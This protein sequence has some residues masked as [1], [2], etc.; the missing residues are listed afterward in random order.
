MLSYSNLAIVKF[1]RLVASLALLDPSG[2][3]NVTLRMIADPDWKQFRCVFVGLNPHLLNVHS[4]V[5]GTLRKWRK[6]TITFIMNQAIT[7]I[8]YTSLQADN[9]RIY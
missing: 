2:P 6:I 4:M 7:T 5:T 9:Y 3:N 8:T 1:S